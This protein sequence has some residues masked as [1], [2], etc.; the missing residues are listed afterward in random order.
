MLDNLV[1]PWFMVETIEMCDVEAIIPNP[2]VPQRPVG[3]GA[4]YRFSS[5]SFSAFGLSSAFYYKRNMAVNHVKESSH[6]SATTNEIRSN[7]EL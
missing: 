4:V 1:L 5:L 7:L 3:D 2:D 6:F